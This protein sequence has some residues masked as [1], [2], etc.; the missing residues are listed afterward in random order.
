MTPSKILVDSSYLFAFFDTKNSK[1]VD[2]VSVA[3]L[4]SGQFVVPD[5]VLTEVAY[6]FNREGGHICYTPIPRSDNSDA[7]SA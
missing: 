5:V 6:L 7:T 2:A 3:D 4:Y 1:H